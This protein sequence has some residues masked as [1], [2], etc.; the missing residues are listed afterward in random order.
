MTDNHR[1][2]HGATV[3]HVYVRSF[4]DSNGD[5]YGDLRGLRSRLDYLEW[6]GVD[7]IWLSPINPSPD[8]DWG[9]D[10]SDYRDVHPDLGTLDDLE[11]LITDLHGRNMRLVLDLVPNHTSDRHAWFVE[12]RSSRDSPYRD[13]YVWAD[14]K[15]DGAPP[16]NWTDDVGD[17]AW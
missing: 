3:Y 1:W 8:C 5:G 7:A 15:P 9:Y 12:S 4:A 14:A 2:W 6:L 13:Y 17:G 11:N 10:V 16:N